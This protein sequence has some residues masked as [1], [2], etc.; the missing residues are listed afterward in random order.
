MTERMV[1]VELLEE[2][3]RDLRIHTDATCSYVG[4]SV[5]NDIRAIIDGPGV[6][7]VAYAPATAQPSAGACPTDKEK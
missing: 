3:E 6:E 1:P 7:P 4:R 2:I 5:L